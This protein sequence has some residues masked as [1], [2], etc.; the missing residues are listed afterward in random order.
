MATTVRTI[1]EAALGLSL[2]NRRTTIANEEVE[3]VLAVQRLLN[4]VFGDAATAYP[5]YF[6]Y[7]DTV[8]YSGAI[9]GWARPTSAL[10]VYRI[11]KLDGTEVV[12][13]SDRDR[14]AARF[15]PSLV[16]RGRVFYSGASA[17]SPTTENL[18]FYFARRPVVLSLG[19]GALD[20]N[21]D[22]AFPDE[23]AAVLVYGL[24]IYLAQKDQRD[25]EIPLLAEQ[26]QT[27]RSLWRQSLREA[28]LNTRHRFAP[29]SVDTP[30]TNVTIKD[31]GP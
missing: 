17:G 15:D 19:S 4:E 26:Y 7:K 29:R 11:E 12:V 5:E 1:V 31:P 25:G 2:R 30:S 6:G 22:S 21:I 9:G 10:A 16:E 23:F 24:A 20:Q 28:T 18:V 27:W 13:V 8:T 14:D 3:L